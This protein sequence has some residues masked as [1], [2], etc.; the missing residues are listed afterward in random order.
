MQN[1]E[2]HLD[3]LE[4][5][6]LA[7]TFGATL[8][9]EDVDYLFNLLKTNH[10]ALVRACAFIITQLS[11]FYILRLLQEFPLLTYK[12]KKI[13]IFYLMTTN[14]VDVYVFLLDLLISTKNKDLIYTLVTFLSKTSYMIFPLILKRIGTSKRKSQAHLE[15]LLMKMGFEKCEPYLAALPSIPHET[16]FR[17]VFGDM[18]IDRVKR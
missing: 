17:R 14:H 5:F 7:I 12:S 13:V 1:L 9:M 8:P 10:E 4:R 6:H 15:L 18:L 3:Q 11:K 16:V 2:A